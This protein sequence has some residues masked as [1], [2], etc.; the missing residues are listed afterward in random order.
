LR[1]I[2]VPTFVLF[3]I[4]TIVTMALALTNY[5]TREAILEQVKLQEESARKEV[6]S[7]AESFEEVQGIEAVIDSNEDMKCV[8]KVYTS[9]KN[10]ETVGRVYSV[11]TTGYGGAVSVAVGIDKGGKTTGVKIVSHSETPGLGSKAADEP[12]ISQFTGITPK[13]PLIVVKSGGSKDEEIDAVSGATITSKAVV[14]AVQAALMV[15]SELNK[16]EGD[17]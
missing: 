1:D 5:A 3:L 4:C 2:V 10:G 15:D 7:E 14:K 11:E 8:K 9:I 12:F 16:R 6:F 13:E 17:S